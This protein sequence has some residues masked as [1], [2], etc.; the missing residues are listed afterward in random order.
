MVSFD[1]LTEVRTELFINGE[2]HSA[3]DSLSIIDP[4]DGVSVVGYAAAASS[5]LATEAVAPPRSHE[6]TALIGSDEGRIG[7]RE[8]PVAHGV[9]T[10]LRSP[11]DP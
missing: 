6:P 3:D 4:A 9:L 10:H 5:K 7:R 1:Q 2:P 11:C 8:A